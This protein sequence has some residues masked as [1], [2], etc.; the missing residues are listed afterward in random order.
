MNG[1]LRCN[2]FN[3]YV[4]TIPCILRVP[5]AMRHSL[6]S[7]QGQMAFRLILWRTVAGACVCW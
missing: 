3:R 5:R 4:L 2:L 1:C 6:L 7:H